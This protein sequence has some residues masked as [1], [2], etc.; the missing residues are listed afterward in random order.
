MSGH[1]VNPEDYEYGGNLPSV[2]S[3]EDATAARAS[4]FRFTT[5][6]T[7]ALLVVAGLAGG[8]AFAL[9]NPVKS[10]TSPA[11]PIVQ[12]ES[13]SVQ[14]AEAAASPSATAGTDAS[15][16]PSASSSATSN[17]VLGKTIAVPPAAFDDKNGEREFH[18]NPPAANTATGSAPAPSSS[19]AP[20]GSAASGSATNGTPSFGGGEDH[21]KKRPAGS[22]TNSSDIRFSGGSD[23]NGNDN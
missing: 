9:S 19:Q 16:A 1:K 8:A 7:T 6:G 17:A 23:D 12:T 4:R 11:G 13:S 20:S 2:A 18:E 10:L 5:V 14:A 15:P 3:A 21:H 22:T